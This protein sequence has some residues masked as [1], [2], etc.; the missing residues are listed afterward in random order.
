M[1]VMA[2]CL[3]VMACCL[4]V[5]ACC[6]VVMAYCLVVMACCLIVIP[7]YDR[8]SR[9]PVIRVIF[10][11]TQATPKPDATTAVLSA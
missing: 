6:L 1:V 9:G 3:V 8:G 4:V 5:M 11:L 10:Q 2:C 7:D